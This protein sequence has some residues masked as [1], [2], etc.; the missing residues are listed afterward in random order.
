V[1]DCRFRGPGLR[2]SITVLVSNGA[3]VLYVDSLK[4][5]R[6]ANRAADRCGGAEVERSAAGK[7]RSEW[8]FHAPDGGPLRETN[9]KRS[10]RWRE[11]VAAIGHLKLRVHDLRHTAASVWLGSGATGRLCRGSWDTYQ[12]R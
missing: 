4:N 2:L 7:S 5:R 10:V 6:G 12:L 11:V 3:G 8:L 1:T 9:V